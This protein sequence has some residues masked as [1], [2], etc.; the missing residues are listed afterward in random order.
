MLREWPTEALPGI[1]YLTLERLRDHLEQDSW[2]AIVRVAPHPRSRSTATSNPQGAM[3]IW[4]ES[5]FWAANWGVSG[6]V[7]GGP[8]V[9][10]SAGCHS[11]GTGAG[12]GCPGCLTWFWN[13]VSKGHWPKT[14]QNISDL[15][16]CQK[17][18]F[19]LMHNFPHISKPCAPFN[20]L[21]GKIPWW[22]MGKFVPC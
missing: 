10:K 11:A 20:G 14:C 13:Q 22:K 21:N 4:I 15:V 9:S 7:W 17:V 18:A 12:G 16:V 1:Y 6:E 8:F 5:G 2:S 3:L 19:T